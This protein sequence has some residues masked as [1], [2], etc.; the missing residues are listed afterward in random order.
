MSH[1]N[2]LF[3]DKADTYLTGSKSVRNVFDAAELYKAAASQI[4]ILLPLLSS[5]ASF[6]FPSTHRTITL[7]LLPLPPP[8]V[9]YVSKILHRGCREGRR[10]LDEAYKGWVKSWGRGPEN[11]WILADAIARRIM[12][13]GYIVTE[14]WWN[15]VDSTVQFVVRC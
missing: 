3:G 15:L 10:E 8:D 1:Y 14:E 9:S 12:L 2:T 4:D 13:D 6:P 11:L 7:R 5:P